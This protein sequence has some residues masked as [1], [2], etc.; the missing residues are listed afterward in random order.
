MVKNKN[1]K[2]LLT[3]IHAIRVAQTALQC[4]FKLAH[5]TSMIK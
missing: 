2:A 3:W 1:N 5:L 4:M